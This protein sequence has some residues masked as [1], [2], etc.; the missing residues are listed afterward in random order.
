MEVRWGW[1]PASP[2]HDQH[3]GAAQ[4]RTGRIR[5]QRLNTIKMGISSSFEG[6][7]RNSAARRRRTDAYSTLEGTN[8]LASFRRDGEKQCMGLGP[9]SS[10]G[11]RDRQCLSR[12]KAKGCSGCLHPISTSLSPACS[13]SVQAI[14]L[15]LSSRHSASQLHCGFEHAF[16][17]ET[18]HIPSLHQDS[19]EFNAVNILHC[20]KPHR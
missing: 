3:S 17:L 13:H 9:A 10:A 14:C 15:L 1:S 11:S 4:V 7:P 16:K 5:W 2:A 19:A 12:Q 18:L 8:L 6:M 20:N